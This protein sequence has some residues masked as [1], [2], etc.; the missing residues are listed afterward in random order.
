MEDAPVEEV[1]EETTEETPAE[2][3]AAAPE[4]GAEETEAVEGE[5][6]KEEAPPAPTR[7]QFDAATFKLTVNGKEVEVTGKDLAAAYQRG[8]SGAAKLREA[9]DL[10]KQVE[11]KEQQLRSVA[12]EL[13]TPEGFYQMLLAMKGDPIA[14][15]GDV[16][17]LAQAEAKLT[18]EQ[19]ELRE[20]K[21][22]KAREEQ[23]RK[24]REAQQLKAQEAEQIAAAQDA[25]EDDFE[26]IMDELEI[27]DDEEI[28]DELLLRLGRKGYEAMELGEDP[29]AD[30]LVKEVWAE[31]QARYQR[32][33]GKVQPKPQ[34]PAPA[35]K[36]AIPGT[37]AAPSPKPAAPKAPKAGDR[38][39]YPSGASME[40]IRKLMGGG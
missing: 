3:T 35:K 29:Y 30:D 36:P 22:Q 5:E 32:L 23:E 13:S 18:P 12:K 37:R 1:V 24:A 20:L 17:K 2:E 31:Y 19:R 10:R 14:F 9:A 16:A 4:E 15:L 26:D 34:A 11:A 21:G 39:V 7:E 8:E 33:G 28:R 40:D 38:F 25:I 6:P 27:P